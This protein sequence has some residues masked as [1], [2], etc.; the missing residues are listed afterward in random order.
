MEGNSQGIL[1]K[2]MGQ[3]LSARAGSRS[4]LAL[5]LTTE[6]NWL[7]GYNP[8]TGERANEHLVELL[9]WLL[10]GKPRPQ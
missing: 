2:Y 4:Q 8:H 3:G 6:E 9:R 7:L 5:D 1:K 10:K